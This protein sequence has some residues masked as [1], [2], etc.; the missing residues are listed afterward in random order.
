[1]NALHEHLRDY[2]ALRRGLGFRLVEAELH[3][4]AFCNFMRCRDARI[5]TSALAIAWATDLPNAQPASCAGRLSSVRGFARYLHGIDGRHEVPPQRLLPYSPRRRQPYLYTDDEVRDLMASAA[6]MPSRQ[7]LRPITLACLIGLLA[8]TGMRI[9]EALAL[10]RDDVDLERGLLTIRR[11]K[12]GKT[13]LVPLH[14]TSVAALARYAHERDA[15]LGTRVNGP[16]F[17]LTGRGRAFAGSEARLS[18]LALCRALRL[19]RPVGRHRGPGFHDFRHRFATRTLIQWA[20]DGVDVERVM[21]VLTTFL[22]HTNIADTYWY[23]SACP[24]LLE[25]AATRVRGR[26]EHGR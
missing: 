26:W 13:R 18:F 19:A 21:P 23:L 3:L 8:V 6:A 25:H 22:G 5:V 15:L 7:T 20:R 12:F 17:L 1:M 16:Q 10:T 2:L 11:T 24:E 9:S 14:P 4:N